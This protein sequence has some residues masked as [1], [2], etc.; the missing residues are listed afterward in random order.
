MCQT[1]I[2]QYETR[3]ICAMTLSHNPKTFPKL[4]L[5][6]IEPRMSFSDWATQVV[7]IVFMLFQKITLYFTNL[8]LWEI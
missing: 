8:F 5:P 3:E 7:N 2:T 4:V 6:G 1:T